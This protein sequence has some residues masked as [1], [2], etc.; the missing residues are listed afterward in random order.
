MNLA[1]NN[2]FFSKV[3]KYSSAKMIISSV[4]IFIMSNPSSVI[5]ISRYWD[6]KCEPLSST[7]DVLEC[8]MRTNDD[9]YSILTSGRASLIGLVPL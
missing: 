4:C 2:S 5:V 6:L 8:K 9:C 7:L 3:E 1:F